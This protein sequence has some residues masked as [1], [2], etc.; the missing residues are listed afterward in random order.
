MSNKKQNDATLEKKEENLA[1]KLFIR[2]RIILK[3]QMKKI[4][5]MR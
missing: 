2:K 5:K 1:D 3:N 4:L